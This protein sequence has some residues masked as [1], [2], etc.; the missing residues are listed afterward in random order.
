MRYFDLPGTKMPTVMW[1]ILHTKL[2]LLEI[3]KHGLYYFPLQWA[4]KCQL[5]Q[6]EK[7]E[8]Q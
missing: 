4:K 3:L 6:E 1:I 5:S 2:Y 7:E 8:Q